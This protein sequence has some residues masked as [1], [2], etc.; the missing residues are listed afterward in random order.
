VYEVSIV[1]NCIMMLVHVNS[2]KYIPINHLI[3]LELKWYASYG[4]STPA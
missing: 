4:P 1:V 2:M 3:L